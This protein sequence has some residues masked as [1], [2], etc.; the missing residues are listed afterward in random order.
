MLDGSDT[1]NTH[2]FGFV[3]IYFL[4]ALVA[5]YTQQLNAAGLDVRVTTDDGE[6]V[7]N[8]VVI[9]TEDEGGLSVSGTSAPPSGLTVAMNQRDEAFVPEVM[10]VHVGTRVTFPNQDD[11]LHHV[12][13]FSAPKQFEMRLNAGSI[14]EGIL[15]DVPG[16]VAVGCNI[17]DDM[18]GHIYVSS[19]PLFTV[20][21]EEGMVEFSE[22]QPGSYTLNV[23]HQRL[24]GREENFSQ[25]ITISADLNNSADVQIRL[26]RQRNNN[27]RR[28]Y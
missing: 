3:K 19:S 27:S 1:M 12:Y 6:P 5:L 13:S 25:A 28:R 20:S 10:P 21:N 14:G 16:V 2:V 9:L 8:A 23:W 4:L 7:Q 26:R 11:K 18:V 17:H 24:R 22:L 15:F